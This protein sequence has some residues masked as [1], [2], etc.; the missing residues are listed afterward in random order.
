[1]EKLWKINKGNNPVLFV[2]QHNFPQIRENNIKPRDIKTGEIAEML[3]E[4]FSAFSIVTTQVQYDP[5][6]YENSDFR[7]EVFEIIKENNIKL[8]VDIHGRKAQSSFKR[9]IFMNKAF[10]LNHNINLGEDWVEMNFKNDNQLTLCEDLESVNIPS[11]ELELR[12]DVRENIILGIDK[13][14]EYLISGLKG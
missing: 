14:I 12:L 3:S 8:V 4:K 11:V 5:N 13:S 7:K 10:S 9:E 2:A 6:W 1:M